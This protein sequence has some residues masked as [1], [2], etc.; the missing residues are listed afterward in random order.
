MHSTPQSAVHHY[1]LRVS[2]QD[3]DLS[4]FV[5]HANYLA[6]AERAR[7]EML[8]DGGIDH[9]ALMARGEGFYV[10]SEARVR[11]HRPARLDDKLVILSR[12]TRVGASAAEIEQC[13]M[14]GEELLARIEV[15]TAWLSRD[16]RPQRQPPE[17]RA[18]F[19]EIVAATKDA[20]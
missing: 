1:A 10:V 6:Y 16:G 14:R 12:P 19:A 3:T 9:A 7:T 4:G 13:V 2:I 20:W 18:R 11:F 8:R 15:K 5:Y 17:W